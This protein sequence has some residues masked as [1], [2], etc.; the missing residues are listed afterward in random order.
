MFQF[1][2]V[3][4]QLVL[5]YFAILMV[6]GSIMITTASL[7]A[8]NGVGKATPF[9]IG[10]SAGAGGTVMMVG[11]AMTNAISAFP[12]ATIQQLGSLALLLMALALVRAPTTPMGSKASKASVVALLAAGV[13]AA[14]SSPM[15][16]IFAVNLLKNEAGS[17]QKPA[18]AYLAL[19]IS[20]MNL[21]WYSF[22]AT[23]LALP[24][25]RA[26]AVRHLGIVRWAAAGLLCTIAVNNLTQQTLHPLAH[27]AVVME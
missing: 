21:L 12:L 9:V 20:A 13:A 1:Q 18:I 17:L 19:T 15:T 24:R 7:A 22:V 4:L 14:I 10:A 26:F 8:E 27:D 23:A 2:T 16:P 11:A 6:P 25:P 3:T 5:A